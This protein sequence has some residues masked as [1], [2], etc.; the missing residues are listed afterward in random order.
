MLERR[1]Y[2]DEL[3][4]ILEK[5]DFSVET[6]NLLLSAFYKIL[7]SYRDFYTVKNEIIDEKQYIEYLFYILEH[8][9]NKIILFDP[10]LDDISKLGKKMYLVNRTHGIILSVNRE[11]IILEAIFALNEIEINVDER[12]YP[13][14]KTPLNGFLHEGYRM[15]LVEVLRDFN[16]WSWNPMPKLM[17]NINFNIIYQTL[18]LLLGNNFMESWQF[19]LQLDGQNTNW[20]F[21]ARKNIAKKYGIVASQNLFSSFQDAVI[22]IYANEDTEFRDYLDNTLISCKSKIREMQAQGIPITEDS[23]IFTL[24]KLM[25]SIGVERNRNID[26]RI[27]ERKLIMEYLRIFLDCFNTKVKNINDNQELERAIY[28]LRYISSLPVNSKYAIKDVAIISEDLLKCQRELI[29]KAS[30]N[31]L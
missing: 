23:R 16:G 22:G 28:E 4:Q 3:E 12:I 11:E 26:V 5:K 8:R 30:K 25:Q 6:K 18:L 31:K 7:S 15:N 14:L 27:D 29:T 24:Y 13:F 21:E 2:S 9:C 20:L 10:F 19:Q 1:N 17:T